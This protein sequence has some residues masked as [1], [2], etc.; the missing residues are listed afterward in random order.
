MVF[1]RFGKSV[2][3][4]LV[5]LLVGAGAVLSPMSSFAN[6][7]T[8][9]ITLQNRIVATSSLFD[10]L[11]LQYRDPSTE[12]YDG[13]V[14]DINYTKQAPLIGQWQP[15]IITSIGTN[16]LERERRPTSSSIPFVYSLRV[17]IENGQNII[18]TTEL[19]L[20]VSSNATYKGLDS[21]KHYV[22]AYNINSN[23][24][25]NNVGFAN[26]VNVRDVATNCNSTYILPGVTNL[27][28]LASQTNS[29]GEV[30]FG[31]GSLG[32]EWNL[33]NSFANSGGSNS[34]SGQKIVSYDSSTNVAVYANSGKFVDKVV[35]ITTDNVGNRTTTTNS[36]PGQT[37][38]Y[39]VVF[40]NTKGSNSVESF[41]GDLPSQNYTVDVSTV[42]G[43][44]VP[45]VGSYVTNTV[46]GALIFQLKDALQADPT[47]SRMRFRSLGPTVNGNDYTAN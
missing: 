9:E 32:C 28:I 2:G 14:L 6:T 21:Q 42:H 39:N 7:S 37:N 22:L 13:G 4:G 45:A 24:I 5:M 25:A 15:K 8:N 23:F 27:N 26:K 16:E 34:F 10:Q 43:T 12:G 29:Q 30:I 38:Y 40:N 3:K 36:V 1:E 11:A 47:N 31:E 18:G 35:K 17:I 44:A 46:N 41:F 20:T 19:G 33:V